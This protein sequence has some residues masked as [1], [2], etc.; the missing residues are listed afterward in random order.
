[1]KVQGLSRWIAIGLICLG[2]ASTG[3][4]PALAAAEGEPFPALTLPDVTMGRDLDVKKHFSGSVGALVFMQTSCAAC[5]KE[6][7]AFSEIL[8]K[9]PTLKIIAV[10]VDSG[11]GNR[12]DRYREGYGFT[13]PFV[14]DPE[15][16]TP[17]IFGFSFTPALVLVGKD[18]KIAQLKGGFRPGDE[19]ALESKIAEMVK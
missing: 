4:L 19:T 10:S 1:M 11:G 13:F 18:G 15:F 8:K 12:V 7:N 2:I 17:E 16:K 3:A 6:L 14:H 5:R 9:H